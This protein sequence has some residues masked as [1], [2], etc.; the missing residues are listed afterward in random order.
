MEL[1][2]EINAD[3]ADKTAI[4]KLENGSCAMLTPPIGSG[5][6]LFRVKVSAAQAIIGFKK[7]ST[8]GIGFAIEKDWNTNLPYHVDAQKIYAH[9][10]HNKGNRN[11]RRTDCISAIEMIRIAAAEYLA[12]PFISA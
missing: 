12:K 11:I 4:I 6:W 5:Y 3:D 9:I 7:F 8:I 10:G 1:I 2:L